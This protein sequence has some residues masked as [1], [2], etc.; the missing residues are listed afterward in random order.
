L[1]ARLDDQLGKVRDLTRRYQDGGRPAFRAFEELASLLL[2]LT[3]LDAT[4]IVR[5]TYG[6]S[7]DRAALGGSGGPTDP[8]PLNDG[9]FLRVSVSL[10]LTER[11]RLAVSTSSYQ[12]QVDRDG[13]RWIFRYDYLREPGPQPH[14]SAHF[15]VRGTLSESDV[16]GA[17]QPLDRVHFPTGRIALEGVIRCLA[18]QFHVQCN[19][20]PEVWRPLLAESEQ[21]FLDV[22]HRPL[23]GPG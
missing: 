3:V 10:Y 5:L 22:A 14:P 7:R 15:Q 4:G 21:A 17:D 23:S 16:L 9:R 1:S 6:T 13:D 19:Q 8:L 20:P 2:H 18:E 12:Y 11:N